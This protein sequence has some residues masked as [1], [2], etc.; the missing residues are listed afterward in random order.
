MTIIIPDYNDANYNSLTN[1]DD[2]TI[3]FDNAS[4]EDIIETLAENKR[5][6]KRS[7]QR[8]KEASVA[9]HA[10]VRERSYNDAMVNFL[11]KLLLEA[12]DHHKSNLTGTVG[13]HGVKF[14]DR[15]LDEV[16]L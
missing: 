13:S 10:E 1:Y 15:A 11:T 3:K 5:L 6:A 12:L 9:Q 4:L 2:F 16:H 8:V 7:N 14:A